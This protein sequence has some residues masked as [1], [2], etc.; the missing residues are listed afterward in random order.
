MLDIIER[1]DD[2][3]CVTAYQEKRKEN[4]VIS[5]VKSA[6]YKFINKIPYICTNQI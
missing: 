2:I 3:D 1:D 4:A 6:F 5:F